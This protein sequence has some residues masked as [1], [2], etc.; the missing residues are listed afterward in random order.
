MTVKT[1]TVT[2]DAYLA[3]KSLK[4]TSES[5]SKTILRVAKRKPL[6]SFF[7]VLSKES[8]ERLENAVI[9]ARK[10][11]NEAHRARME[12]IVDALRG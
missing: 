3:L 7:G 2:E 5:F 6:S 9:E 10:R 1:I 11:R 12:K 8:G 4:A